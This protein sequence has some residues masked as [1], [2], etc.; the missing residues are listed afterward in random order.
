MTWKK[1]VD[2]RFRQ[3]LQDRFGQGFEY[4]EATPN[5]QQFDDLVGKIL[6]HAAVGP[7]RVFKGRQYLINRFVAMGMCGEC[8][9][10]ELPR[11]VVR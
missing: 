7:V 6:C 5:E 8:G 9:H 1:G 11:G 4:F 3:A 2:E 10:G